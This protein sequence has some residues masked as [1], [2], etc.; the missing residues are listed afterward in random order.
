MSN[1][2]GEALQTQHSTQIV[3]LTTCQ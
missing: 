3:G 1:P 2:V